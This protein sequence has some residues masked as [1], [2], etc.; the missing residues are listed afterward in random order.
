[1]AATPRFLFALRV[2]LDSPLLKRK[3]AFSV[4]DGGFSLACLCERLVLPRQQLSHSLS[5]RVTY[6]LLIDS[7]QR[8]LSLALLPMHRSSSSQ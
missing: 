7:Q 1:M 5:L 8:A 2:T 6:H 3:P 4:G